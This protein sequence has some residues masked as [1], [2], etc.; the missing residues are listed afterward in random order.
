MNNK[1]KALDLKFKNLTELVSS[2]DFSP[3]KFDYVSKALDVLRNYIDYSELF[4]NEDDDL[5]YLINIGE[6]KKGLDILR[7]FT[8]DTD[9]L[10]II[11]PYF[12]SG[13]KEDVDNYKGEVKKITNI[14]NLKRLSIVYNDKEETKVYKSELKKLA[15]QSNCRLSLI[16]TNTI[17]D[18]I[19][20][21]DRSQGIVVGTSIG[22]IGKVR[23]SFIFKLPSADLITLL[24]H[25][26][27][28]ELI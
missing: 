19:W 9:N 20:I 22:G 14:Q 15:S 27:T 18:R 11:D 10:I 25:I 13:A 8:K 16:P 6:R 1:N 2:K 5:K 4:E 3:E 23:L 26:D 17:H 24:T 7:E 21:K 28:T 12:L